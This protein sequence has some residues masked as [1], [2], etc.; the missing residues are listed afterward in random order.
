MYIC[1]DKCY[2]LVPPQ[3]HRYAQLSDYIDKCVFCGICCVVIR[4]GGQAYTEMAV[5]HLV[6]GMWQCPCC[7]ARPRSYFNVDKKRMEHFI[8]KLQQS[9]HFVKIVEEYFRVR[10]QYKNDVDRFKELEKHLEALAAPESKPKKS[11]AM[12]ATKLVK[13]TIYPV[14]Q[15]KSP[16]QRAVE[17][18]MFPQSGP[19]HHPPPS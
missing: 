11:K 8:K 15:T 12:I 3:D 4:V 2:R 5:N 10:K 7:S 16:I 9:K 17:I 6:T 19:P 13:L 18:S 1:Q 14:E